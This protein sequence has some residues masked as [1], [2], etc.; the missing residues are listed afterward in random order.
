MHDCGEDRV[1][2]DRSSASYGLEIL[3]E[4]L[5]TE[6]RNQYKIQFKNAKT[7]RY[8]RLGMRNKD[9]RPISGMANADV[10]LFV[11]SFAGLSHTADALFGVEVSHINVKKVGVE[12]IVLEIV[13][14]IK[15]R[16]DEH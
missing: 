6:Q 14:S 1:G 11:R 10:H 2:R 5:T 8:L 9:D 4:L 16:H 3:D 15:T 12:I 13:K 7:A